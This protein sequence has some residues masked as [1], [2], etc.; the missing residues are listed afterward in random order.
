MNPD[1][2]SSKD[3]INPL[4]AFGVICLSAIVV[5]APNGFANIISALSISIDANDPAVLFLANDVIRCIA[6]F[7]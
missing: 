6:Y 4:I 5:N 1:K 2:A 7:L 3:D